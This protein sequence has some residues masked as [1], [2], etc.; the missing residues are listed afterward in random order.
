MNDKSSRRKFH[1]RGLISILA[2]LTMLL[3]IATGIV[4]FVTP[5]GRVAHWMDWRVLGLTKEQWASVHITITILFVIL[6]IIHLAFNWKIFWKYLTG[7]MS[8]GRRLWIEMLLA[9]TICMAVVAGTISQAP[10][11]RQI[12]KLNEDIKAYWEKTSSELPYAHAED[13]SLR[14]FAKRI[15]L[16]HEEIE[17]AL[18]NKADSILNFDI[19]I[20]E[21]A[22]K[23]EM[24][25]SELFETIRRKHPE[26]GQQQRGNKFSGR[27]NKHKNNQ[28]YYMNSKVDK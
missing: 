14:E 15:G 26:V 2:G 21:L 17:A 4:L 27:N 18:N 7:K 9:T 12:I 10:P 28:E 19:T 1:G 8:F 22:R 20:G 25:P 6:A 16:S 5:R 13:S 3:M 24:S 11:F 23:M